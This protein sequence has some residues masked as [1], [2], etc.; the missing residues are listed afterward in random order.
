LRLLAGTLALLLLAGAG[1]GVRWLL[2]EAAALPRFQIDPARIA[3]KDLPTWVSPEVRHQL[4][5][6]HGLRESF[7]VFDGEKLL[8]IQQRYSESPWVEKVLW[9]RRV[10]P[11]DVDIGLMLRV[12]AAYGCAT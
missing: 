5:R 8:E 12:P 11:G 3:V 10:Y 4:N 9:V 6:S 1:L 7:S 2:R